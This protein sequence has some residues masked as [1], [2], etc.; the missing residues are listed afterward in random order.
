LR[1]WLA[2]EIKV[3]GL[4]AQETEKKTGGVASVVGV[5][6]SGSN[7]DKSGKRRK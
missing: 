4:A 5:E 1:K 2:K 6:D 7:G 3:L